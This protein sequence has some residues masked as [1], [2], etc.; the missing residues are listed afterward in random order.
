MT[1]CALDS[2]LDR[3]LT[4]HLQG[5]GE[6]ESANSVRATGAEPEYGAW[7]QYTIRSGS[8]LRPVNSLT[9]AELQR[10]YLDV[11]WEEGKHKVNVRSFLG[12]IDEIFS[13]LRF[14]TFSDDMVDH[15]VGTL[16][17]RNRLPAWLDWD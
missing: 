11:L 1:F 3:R 9:I 8:H 13:G 16:R 17:E 2:W 15:L 14:A 5:G 7:L 6:L 4:G 10:R 12:E